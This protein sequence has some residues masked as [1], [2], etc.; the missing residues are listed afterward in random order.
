MSDTTTRGIRIQVESEYMEERSDPRAA[1]FFFAYHIIIANTGDAP[2]QLVARHWIITDG[3][4]N[5][6]HVQG[7]GVIGETPRL[8]PGTQFS[9]T[10][11]CPLRTSF[12]LME[13]HYTMKTDSGET[14]EAEIGGFTLAVPGVVN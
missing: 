12:G 9:Y 14:F 7:P 11:F 1:Y 2:A 6:E 4:G 5:V 10:S 8:V 13:G 3:D